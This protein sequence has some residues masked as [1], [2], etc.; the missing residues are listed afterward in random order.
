MKMKGKGC[1]TQPTNSYQCIIVTKVE[2]I[3]QI[4]CEE[5]VNDDICTK[6]KKLEIVEPV[7]DVINFS[8]P[9]QSP[10][11]SPQPYLEPHPPGTNYNVENQWVDDHSLRNI[12]LLLGDDSILATPSPTLPILI[13]TSQFHKPLGGTI[14]VN[15]VEDLLRDNSSCT[16]SIDQCLNYFKYWDDPVILK[17]VQALSLATKSYKLEPDPQPPDR[18]YFNGSS[19][20]L[21]MMNIK[22]HFLVY[23]VIPY[24]I[25]QS[26]IPHKLNKKNIYLR[27][28]DSELFL[29]IMIAS[30]QLGV[31]K[32]SHYFS[33]IWLFK[34]ND[35]FGVPQLFKENLQPG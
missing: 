17:I 22:I 18:H 34:D 1:L 23:G 24:K 25:S 35:N 11:K 16:Y 20:F 2:S 12:S 30:A 6:F 19:H 26:E 31:N 14:I 28:L 13:P 5:F 21:K 8:F 7:A 32:E 29:C 10:Y 33:I 27:G 15:E 9:S 4:A 3:K